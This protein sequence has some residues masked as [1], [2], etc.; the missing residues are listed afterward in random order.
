MQNIQVFYK[1]S[2]GVFDYTRIIAG[3]VGLNEEPC[4][5]QFIQGIKK[6]SRHFP[7]LRFPPPS[8]SLKGNQEHLPVV[9]VSYTTVDGPLKNNP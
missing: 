4:R 2:T 1:F 6:R 7:F 3:Y 8:T 9:G 5:P